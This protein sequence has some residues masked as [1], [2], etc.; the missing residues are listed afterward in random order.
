VLIITSPEGIIKYIN[1][2]FERIT[3][4]T[5]TEVPGRKLDLVKTGFHNQAF[6]PHFRKS[7]VGGELF[8]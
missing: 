5:H 7:S 3:A 4:Y 6:I 1:P 2:A 8:Q